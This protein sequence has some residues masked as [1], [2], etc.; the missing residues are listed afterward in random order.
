MHHK[1]PYAIK[2]SDL[3]KQ[4]CAQGVALKAKLVATRE[5]METLH[6]SLSAALEANVELA[7]ENEELRRRG[8]VQVEVE[9][10]A[11]KAKL[12][13]VMYKDGTRGIWELLVSYRMDT[14]KWASDEWLE[15]TKASLEEKRRAAAAK[16]AQDEL[17]RLA[18]L[19]QS[20]QHRCSS[21][22]LIIPQCIKIEILKSIEILTLNPQ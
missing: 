15:D 18:G 12:K 2:G 7:A 4:V 22:Q 11:M 21:I 13:K 19:N 1:S 8:P 14:L 16:A 5:E 3:L 6:E 9:D 10:E 20:L 17:D